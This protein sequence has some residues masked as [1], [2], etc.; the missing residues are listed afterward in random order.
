MGARR[1]ALTL[2]L[3]GAAWGCNT[4]PF[5]NPLNETLSAEI[6]NSDTT[7]FR[8][9]SVV[10]RGRAEYVVGPGAPQTVSWGV[11]DTSK[12]VVV[13]LP[14]LTASLLAKDT[15]SAYLVAILNQD[16]RDS[17]LI[18][19]VDDGLLRW[20]AALPGTISLYPAVAPD[21]NARVV[22]GG[23]TPRLVGYTPAGEQILA[24]A[25]C[26][27]RLAPSLG[28]DGQAYVTGS[29]CTKR[30]TAA[31]AVSW[32]LSAGG[33][34]GGVAIPSD[35]GTVVLAG[36][37]VLRISPT[38]GEVWRDTLSGTA[39]TAPVIASD[40]TIY[41]A[42]SA[43]AGADSVTSY[44]S[45]GSERWTVGVPG[46]PDL[47]TP[48]I[49]GNRVVF[50]WPGGLFVVDA[51]GTLLWERAFAAD[52]TAASATAPASSPVVDGAGVIFVQTTD[53][54]Y[55]YD[56]G[57]QNLWFADSLGYGPSSTGVGAPS[58][59]VDVSL[60]VPCR[61]AA[62][63]VREI[64]AVR[65]VSGALVWRS[66]LGSGA[67]DGLAVGN[68]GTLFVSRTLSGGSSELVAVWSRVRSDV[69]GWP[70]EGGDMARSRRN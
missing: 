20:R 14:N 23:A 52:N 53:A 34:G 31:G 56:S 22:H 69:V 68:E 19:V 27:S 66:A 57:G 38:G 1:A 55:S 11:S 42:W 49:T 26:D 3:A 12:I 67:S 50:T 63:G 61:G 6:D 10:F 35:G 47:A 7:M 2:V 37:T 9:A 30:H 16:F 21:S 45:T 51:T 18:T 24:V 5:Q 59:R 29:L 60:V 4:S 17:V 48:A 40:G 46:A 58:L 54:L 70:T 8:G 44:T 62:S 41:V 65:N 36:D 15:G 25:S 13:V 39:R 32:A 43:G 33:A 28:L 64:C